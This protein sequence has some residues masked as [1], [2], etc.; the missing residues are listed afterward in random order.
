MQERA[1]KT[2]EKILNVAVR[3]F[4]ECGFHG[5]T[6][7]AIADAAEVNKQRIYAYFESKTGLF[8][9]SLIHVLGDMK[10]ISGKV[11]AEA[12]ENPARLT[13]ILL[14]EYMSVHKR[15]PYFW[16][17]LAW[18]NLEDE[19]PLPQLPGINHEHYNELAAIFDRAREQA[20]V[21][22]DMSFEVYIFLLMS[23]SFFYN[24]N[25][26]TL[27]QTLSKELFTATGQKLLISQCLGLFLPNQQ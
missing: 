7:D 5:T 6:V 2:R 8:E 13:E 1:R 16:R 14:N 27:S 22:A 21:P 25:R 24:S 19:T 3:M 12:N 26:K 9:S 17:M 11:L 23:V 20:A 18:A 10:L 4:A 15:N